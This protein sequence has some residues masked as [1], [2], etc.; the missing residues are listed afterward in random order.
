MDPIDPAEKTFDK[1]LVANRGEIACRVIKTA[2]AMGIKTVAVYSI[3]D[4]SSVSTNIRT[5]CS[6][7]HTFLSAF[8]KHV[9]LADESVFIGAAAAKDSYLNTEKIIDAINTT[10]SQAVHPG[11]GFLSENATFVETLVSLLLDIYLNT[12]KII[13]RKKKISPSSGLPLKPLQVWAINWNP[14][15]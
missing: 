8:Q 7:I 14:K 2:K 15:D 1:L 6:H 12:C 13:F 11:Y 4:A 5:N 3:A 9:K 10:G